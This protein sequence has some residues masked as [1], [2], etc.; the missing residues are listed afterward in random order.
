MRREHT[1]SLYGMLPLAL[2][3][4]LTWAP[5]LALRTVLFRWAGAVPPAAGGHVGG[6]SA[7]HGRRR[8]ALIRRPSACVPTPIPTTHA[9]G[10]SCY[11]MAHLQFSADKYFIFLAAQWFMSATASECTM[12]VRTLRFGRPC[13][14]TPPALAHPPCP[15]PCPS[16]APTQCAWAP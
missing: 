8:P 9:C 3:K 7:V 2:S 13:R 5:M 14:S 1:I 10:S 12:G 4:G 16:P 11:W 15:P 6:Q